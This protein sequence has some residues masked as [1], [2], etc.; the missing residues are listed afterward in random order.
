MGQSSIWAM[1]PLV[2]LPPRARGAYM[3]QV[4]GRLKPGVSI[5]A[6]EAD[7]GAVADGSR[8][9]VPADQQGPRREARADARFDHRQRSAAHVDAVPRRRRIR[10]PHLLRQRR[11]PV[12]R[13]RHGANA[14]AGGTV[15]ARRRPSP[16]RPAAV[17]REHRAG[18]D[19]RRARNRDRRG[20]SRA[21]RHRSFQQGL[22][23]ATVSLTFDV[24]V[25]AFCA[26]AALLVG[27]LFGVM[28]AWK[29]TAFS[30]AEVI[31]SDTRTTT[32]G[33]GRASRAAG[34]R[35][36]RDGRLPA[37]WRRASCFARCSLSKPSI[38]GIAP[39]ASSRCS[40]IR[41]GSKYPTDESLQQ[42]YE[43][44][45]AEDRRRAGRGRR[46]VG[47]RSAARFLRFRRVL[48][49]DRRRPSRATTG[50]GR[51]RSIRSSARHIS[52]RSICPSWPDAPSIG[53]IRRDGVPVCIVNEAFAR[54][55]PRP[56]TG[57][58]AHRVAAD[59]RRRR[60]NRVVR[61]IVG[62]ARQVKGRPDETA[63]FVQIYVPMAQDLSDDIFLVVRPKSGA[64]E[65]LAPSVRAAISRVD[66][67]QLVS[68]QERHD[69]RRHRAGGHRPSSVPR[70]DGDGLCGAGARPGDGGSLRDSRL[71]GPAERAG[72][73]RA[74]G[75]WRDD[76]RRPPPWCSEMPSAS[77]VPGRRSA[78]CWRP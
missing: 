48:V 71:L 7:L 63:D 20:D 44:V 65:A 54:T 28:P 13:A 72:F 21:W 34:H 57:R 15:C 66:T 47:E 74:P 46:R 14:R 4:V 61:E 2:N 9:R 5:E 31:G 38:A 40:W 45:E 68:V 27:L 62:V 37:V 22:L 12:A 24:R 55:V 10:A 41:L 18:A 78:S 59:L 6:A 39:K 69:A 76:T 67:E 23:P 43:Q 56:F 64:A 19:R 42:F 52:R 16:H 29:A 3:L 8:A 33:G 51:A 30:P 32:G 58:P 75:A 73:R 1:R 70:R 50:S 26:A 77:S 35:R 17:D 11:Q 49:R 25:V 36:G 60:P 53:V